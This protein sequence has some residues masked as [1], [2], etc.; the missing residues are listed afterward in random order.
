MYEEVLPDIFKIAVTLPNNPLRELNAYLVRGTGRNLLIDNGFNTKESAADLY[1]ALEA[2]EVDLAA[3]DFFLTH[4][5][6]DHNG[7]THG[8]IRSPESKIMCSRVD[9]ERINRFITDET[10]W[11]AMLQ[12]LVRHG[13]PEG[14]MRL[15][16]ETHPGK[17]YASPKPL[18]ITCVR[19]GDTVSCGRYAFTV[20]EVPGHTPGHVSLYE[21]ATRTYVAGDHILGSIS[22]NITRWDGVDDSLGDYLASLDKVAALQIDRTLPGHRGLVADTAGRIRELRQHH[23][24]RLAE[25][26]AILDR[27]GPLQAYETASHMRWSLRGIAWPEFKVQQKCFAAGE[28]LA[29]L[30][31]LAAR[32]LV[33]REDRGDRAFFALG[34][35]NTPHAD[36]PFSQPRSFS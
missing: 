26:L 18:D 8:L 34:S 21:A 27:H 11:C 24:S 5:H 36:R 33:I 25:V 23:E 29:H 17:I 28:A 4:L 35:T 9:G 13:F 32:G 7:L 30:T 16:A 3:T 15:L 2:L 19:D 12:G 1:A 10:Y 31:H 14:E 20:V 6:S 22:P